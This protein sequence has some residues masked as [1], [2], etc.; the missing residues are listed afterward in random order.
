MPE[1]LKGGPEASY[2]DTRCKILYEPPVSTKSSLPEEKFAR[3]NCIYLP[4]VPLLPC[5]EQCW[6]QEAAL[7]YLQCLIHTQVISEPCLL[8]NLWFKQPKVS[9]ARALLP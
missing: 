4:Q 3:S 1:S 8:G 9:G 7:Q 5:Q 2:E 6:L